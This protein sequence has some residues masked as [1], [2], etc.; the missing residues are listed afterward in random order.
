MSEQHLENNFFKIDQSGNLES[1][2]VW[3]LF[4]YLNHLIRIYSV[5][6]IDISGTK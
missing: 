2:A 4:L 5:E 1:V 6:K 3:K